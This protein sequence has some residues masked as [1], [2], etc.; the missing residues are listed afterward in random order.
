MNIKINTTKSI[1]SEYWDVIVIGTGMG[2]ATI[3]YYLAKYGK[4][5]LFLEKGIS[6]EPILKENANL[7]DLESDVKRR[8]AGYWPDKI[9]HKKD[10]H[11]LEFYAALGSGSGG[12]SKLYASQLERFFVEDFSPRQ[13]FPSEIDSTLPDQWPI[14]YKDFV[15]YY[16]IAERL[17]RVRGTNDP[18]NTD[19]LAAYGK[20]PLISDNDLEVYNM[21]GK[22]GMHPYRAH[23][24]CDFIDGCKECVGRA[25]PFSCKNEADKN[26]LT[27]A[28]KDHGA[29][30][31]NNCE[32]TYLDAD[33][34][35][36][37]GVRCSIDNEEYIFKGATVVLSGG[38]LNSPLLLLRSKS[39]Q[40]PDGLANSSGLVGRNLMWHASHFFAL[41]SFKFKNS[42]GAN[43][44]LA[45][46]DFY[47]H[48]GKKMGTIQSIGVPITSD[49]IQS[50][51]ERG[52]NN[53]PK[54]L[55]LLIFK[56][57]VKMAAILGEFFF[58]NSVLLC[59]IV[60]DLPY[61]RNRVCLDEANP[62][63]IIFEYRFTEDLKNRS[64]GL[65]KNI[66]EILK[67]KYLVIRLSRRSENLNFGH[68]CGTLRFGLDPLTSV[69]N[70]DN[71]SHDIS[72]LYV[73]DASF[74]PSS[75][76]TNPSLTIAANSIRVAEKI[77]QIEVT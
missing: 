52:K 11:L 3:G 62:N 16:R 8:A 66:T 50:Y 46:N 55:R 28:V 23:V 18:L 54:F 51:I 59:T 5:V 67:S 37:T 74:F 19:P 25:C 58:K 13:Q 49:Y 56:P 76:G 40:W 33:Q 34:E 71:R 65:I 42:I 21:L 26:C 77:L 68:P 72:N 6:H 61:F 38:A 60:E 53:L 24:A 47:I 69:L 4:K 70:Q 2:G 35:K 75:G 44:T 14:S 32:V 27:P 12:S 48:N 30:L 10:N 64:N 43:K 73:C 15:P 1:E 41:K 63:K 20:E 9:T 39:K 31:I 57:V 22:N 45:L 17:F 36:I 7:S 29:T